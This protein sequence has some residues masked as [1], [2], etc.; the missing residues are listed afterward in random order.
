MFHEIHIRH[1]KRNCHILKPINFPSQVQPNKKTS[2]I[3][4]NFLGIFSQ[5]I[6]QEKFTEACMSHNLIIQLTSMDNVVV[7]EC[8]LKCASVLGKKYLW[9]KK[10]KRRK[11]KNDFFSSV[12]NETTNCVSI[13]D[14]FCRVLTFKEWKNVFWYFLSL[15]K[16]ECHSL[17]SVFLENF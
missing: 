1:K 4:L 13:H 3:H 8:L 14:G 7:E 9:M 2:S 5:S 15:Q 10:K 12:W 6:S 17:K 16:N 11:A